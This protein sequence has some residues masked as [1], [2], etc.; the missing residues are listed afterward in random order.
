MLSVLFNAVFFNSELKATDTQLKSLSVLFNAVFFNS[1]LKAT[2]TQLKSVD[3]ALYSSILEITPLK[4]VDGP[5]PTSCTNYKTMGH[6]QNGFYLIKSAGTSQIKTSYCDFSKATG[7][8]G[9]GVNQA[10]AD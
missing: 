2:D 9:T 6:T 8:T 3:A 5:M 1:E 10:P 4:P 7:T